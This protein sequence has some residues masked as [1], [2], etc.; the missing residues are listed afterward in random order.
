MTP[1]VKLRVNTNLGI[2]K[3]IHFELPEL[4]YELPDLQMAGVRDAA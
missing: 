4:H 1:T 2:C 3:S